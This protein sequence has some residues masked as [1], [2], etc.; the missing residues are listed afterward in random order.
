MAWQQTGDA[1]LMQVMS[2]F[3]HRPVWREAKAPNATATVKAHIRQFGGDEAE[4]I[5]AWGATGV[6]ISVDAA[7]MP[8]E[9]VKFDTFEM[10]GEKWVVGAVHN[11][12]GFTNTLLYYRIYARGGR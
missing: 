1:A 11:M 4:L 9:P 3:N 7:S 8:Q 2:L 6:E 12:Y 5:N 10:D